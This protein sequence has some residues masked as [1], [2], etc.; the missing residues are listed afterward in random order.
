MEL[1]ARKYGPF[2]WRQTPVS[3]LTYLDAIERHLMEVRDG[4]N[5]DP[6]SRVTPVAH[7]GACCAI[8]LDAMA[9][10]TLIDDRFA[11][12]PASKLIVALTTAETTP[13]APKPNT[14][15]PVRKAADLQRMVGVPTAEEWQDIAKKLQDVAE[16]K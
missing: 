8:I 7:I 10:G 15:V 14:I 9:N 6:E 5:E 2:N 4:R 12:G 3:L 16:P 13:P 11:A 1:G